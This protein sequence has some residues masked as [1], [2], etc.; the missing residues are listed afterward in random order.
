M[1]GMF[2]RIHRHGERKRVFRDVFTQVSLT[3]IS[4]YACA[5]P[6]DRKYLEFTSCA[7]RTFRFKHLYEDV[8]VLSV[9]L[10]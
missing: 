10:A 7:E 3:K 6:L 4:F 9:R 8:C 1:N 2:W 5:K